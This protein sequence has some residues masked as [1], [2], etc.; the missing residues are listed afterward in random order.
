VVV[1]IAKV[2]VQFGATV[3]SNCGVLMV[4]WSMKNEARA[5]PQ[6]TWSK[7]TSVGQGAALAWGNAHRAYGFK[8]RMVRHLRNKV[9]YMYGEWQYA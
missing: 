1:G 5:I 7:S 9:S 3:F 4:L 6:L 2:A 8:E